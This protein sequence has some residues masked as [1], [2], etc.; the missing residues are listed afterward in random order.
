MAPYHRP[1]PCP[2]DRSPDR[3]SSQ[4][5][6][7]RYADASLGEIVPSLLAALGAPFR[8]ALAIEPTD[9]A[10]LFLVDGLGW[11]LLRRHR[12]L[13]PFLGSLLAE[14]RPVTAP[15]PASTPVSLSS[16]GTGRPPGEHG[17]TGYTMA[18]PTLDGPINCITWTRYGVEPPV[19]LRATAVPERIQPLPTLLEQA[20]SA[21]ITV[22]LVAPAQFEG[23]GLTRAA[24]RGGRYDGVESIARP[25]ATA[26]V[27]DALHRTRPALVY[28]YHPALDAAGHRHGVDSDEWRGQLR[29]VDG[30]AE[31]LAET[32]P[33][34]GTLVVTGDHGMVDLGRG[35]SERLDIADEPDLREGVRFLAGEA[36]TR[37]VHAEDGAADE[38]LARWHARLGHAMW[39]VSREEAIDAGWFGERVLEH[40]RPRIGDVVAAAFGSIG[41]FD[42][43]VDP[44]MPR[45]VAHHGSMTGDE[46]LVPLLTFRRR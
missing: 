19:D 32:L 40:V 46:Q 44:V 28:T 12:H 1:M 30:V 36:R 29:L 11:E 21:G 8:N 13:A 7:P 24:L 5:S 38:V 6:V 9:S 39:V 27:A 34:A 10:C 23:S 31:R 45:V 33:A 3:L 25:E 43:A 16:L 37:H 18:L 42:R 35:E 26:K 2:G 17:M 4:P 20:A 14:G 22:T 15:F 41:V